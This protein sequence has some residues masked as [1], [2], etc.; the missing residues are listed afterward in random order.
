MGSYGATNI[1]DD[2]YPSG[3]NYWSDYN[4]QGYYLIDEKNIDH[5]PLT[6]APDELNIGFILPI[7]VTIFAVSIAISL[8][9]YRKHKKNC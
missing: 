2:G 9:L 4:G 3:G 5:Y 8:L 1:W 7:A 6:Q